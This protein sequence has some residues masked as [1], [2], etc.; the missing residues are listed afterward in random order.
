MNH[1][2]L[3][4]IVPLYRNC[5]GFVVQIMKHAT[6]LLTIS[7][8]LVLV[9]IVAAPMFT[10]PADAAAVLESPTA[11]TASVGDSFGIVARGRGGPRVEIREDFLA[12]YPTQ[13]NL[14]FLIARQGEHGVILEVLDGEFALN[15]TTFTFDDGLGFAGRPQDERLNGTIVFGFRINM[16]G[17]QGENAQLEFLGRVRR[18]ENNGPF[19][20]MKG[21]LTIGEVIFVFAQAGRIHRA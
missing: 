12:N 14:N 11:A 19:L 20:V 6:K 4:F 5:I 8:V 15:D 16:T 1:L 3:S 10:V 18:T 21:R 7:S 17:P 13:M 2:V 9:F